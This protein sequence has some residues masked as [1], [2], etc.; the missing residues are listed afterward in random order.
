L[1]LL[2]NMRNAAATFGEGTPP[3]ENIKKVVEDHLNEMKRKGKGTNIVKTRQKLKGDGSST[4]QQ[5]FEQT[6]RKFEQTNRE[7]EQVEEVVSS[8]VANLTIRMKSAPS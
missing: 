7:V 1:Q 2:R 8:P 4:E 6:N 3:Y 5:E